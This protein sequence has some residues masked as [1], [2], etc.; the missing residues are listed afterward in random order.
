MTTLANAPLL[1]VLTEF[2]WGTRVPSDDNAVLFDHPPIEIETLFD[3]F[4]AVAAE[5]GFAFKQ[6]TAPESE[7]FTAS[8]GL[9][10]EAGGWPAYQIGIGTLS[11][12]Q[13]NEGYDWP[14]YKRDVLTG[15]EMLRK[16]L[17]G[18][19]DDIPFIGAEMVFVDAFFLDE[20]ETFKSFL[21]KNL[22]IKVR[23]PEAFLASRHLAP[24]P[25]SADFQVRCKLAE[26]EGWLT[27]N[28]DSV[29]NLIGRR[30]VLMNTS[31]LSISSSV[32]ASNAGCAGWLE[33]AHLVQRHAFKT[34]I[35][36]AFQRSFA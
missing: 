29:D 14:T 2:R 28:V 12:H 15:V 7:P 6:T 32:F 33:L 16:S 1:E 27:I 5:I 18:V 20:N 22:R 31:V 30:A 10:R 36:P 24:E 19:Y 23:V 11:V 34:V 21:L 26:P 17:A 8:F 35:Q 25:W 13:A 3:R 9:R 4:A